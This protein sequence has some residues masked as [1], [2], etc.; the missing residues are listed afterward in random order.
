MTAKSKDFVVKVGEEFTIKLD[1][2]P[3]TGYR[4]QPLFD[5]GVLRLV[6]NDFIPTSKMLGSPGMEYFN[7]KA[8]KADTTLIKMI[9]K[10]S[11]EKET[12]KEIEFSVI[13]T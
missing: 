9:Y 3:T 8:R 12:I 10:R 4:W 11:W 7:F 13:I 5:D 2:N 1:S 6:S